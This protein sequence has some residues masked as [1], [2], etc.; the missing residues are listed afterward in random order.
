MHIK[1]LKRKTRFTDGSIG[2]YQE[3]ATKEERKTLRK[4]AQ[5]KKLCA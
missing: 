4:D 1:K 5:R 2:V 3:G